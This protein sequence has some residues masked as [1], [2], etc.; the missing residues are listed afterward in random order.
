M[1]SSLYRLNGFL[2]WNEHKTRQTLKALS[3]K[4]DN[5]QNQMNSTVQHKW[6]E[7]VLI[8]YYTAVFEFSILFPDG[9]LS[10]CMQYE[11]KKTVL[12]FNLQVYHKTHKRRG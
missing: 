11:R 8:S 1:L 9:I 3:V 6:T 12:N 4:G 2:T 5:V 10:Y 7:F